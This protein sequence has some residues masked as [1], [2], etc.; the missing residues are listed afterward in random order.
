[1]AL[2]EADCRRASLSIEILLR[3]GWNLNMN[4]H[5]RTRDRWRTVPPRKPEGEGARAE[6]WS[7]MPEFLSHAPIGK[8]LLAFS[9]FEITPPE[10]GS[11]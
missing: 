1:M 4:T 3:P 9:F 5:T 11:S 7:S 2:T 6:D 8:N 10:T